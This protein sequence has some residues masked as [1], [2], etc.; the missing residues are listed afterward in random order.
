MN[1]V[2]LDAGHI[3][4]AALDN[5]GSGPVILGL[6]GFLD[7]AESLRGLAPYLNAFRFIALD[8]AGH[9]RSDHRPQGSHYN[10]ADYLQDLHGLIER[11][12]W[13]SVILI[14]HS[15]GGILASLYAA[16]FPEKVTAVISID[17]CG[18]L[19]LDATTTQRQ[20]RDAIVS[21]HG[22][23]HTKRRKVNLDDAVTAR[24]RVSDIAPNH[25]RSILSRNIVQEID[26]DYYWCSD[27]KV[28]TKS[29]VR[30]TENQAE[31]LMQAINCP[32]LF[33]G[34]SK[35][36]KRL[37]DAFA[38]RRGWFKNAQYAAFE[39]GHHIHM[40]KSDEIGTLIQRFVG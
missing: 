24:C 20:M 15:M 22:K 35:S 2:R 26:G 32:I 7:N 28:R 13:Q 1:D 10:Q 27:A 37:D 31:N 12:Q 23:Q 36:F 18:P 30:L 19:T 33:I 38:R 25:A 29:I 5:Q 34:A 39:G 9:G 6:H 17:A 11:Q 21:R 4:L 16:L 14:G 3:T 8:L 40:E